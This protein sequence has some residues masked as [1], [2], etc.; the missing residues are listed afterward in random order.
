MSQGFRLQ[1][2]VHGPI[3]VPRIMPT[4]PRLMQEAC[5]RLYRDW[6]R[7]HD[8]PIDQDPVTGYCGSQMIWGTTPTHGL[9]TR[10]IGFTDDTRR[11]GV[12]VT[13]NA[14]KRPYKEGSADRPKRLTAYQGYTI[15][16]IIFYGRGDGQRCADLIALLDGI[17]RENSRACGSFTIDDLDADETESWRLVAHRHSGVD[18]PADLPFDAVIGRQSLVPFGHDEPVLRPQMFLR[19]VCQ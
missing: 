13:R 12:M 19:E 4:L 9:V 7:L 18:D 8:L 2:R 15:P 14:P 16:Y 11:M 3:I 5:S 1:L 10:P 6:S 17:G